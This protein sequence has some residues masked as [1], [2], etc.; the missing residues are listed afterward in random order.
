M[1]TTI[2]LAPTVVP[3][4]APPI[5]DGGV[6]S[7]QGRIIDVGERDRLTA[8]YP[9]AEKCEWQGVMVPGL[10]NAH[11]HL[12]YT[13]FS[14]VGSVR[15]PDY[16]TWSARFVEEYEERR[17][18]DWAQ[19]ARDG[20]HASLRNGTT[21]FADIVTDVA[22]L[23]ILDEMG[24]AGVAYLEV[25]GVDEEAWKSHVEE[26]LAST[27]AEAPISGDSTVGISPHAPYSLDEP[28]LK[29]LAR[30]ANDM[31]RRLHIHLAESDTEDDYYRNGRGALA[32]R[33]AMRV[34]RPWGVLGRGG[35]GMGAAEFA[36]SCGLLGPTTHVAHGVYLG[37]DGRRIL[38]ERNTT[39]ALCPRS[40][41]GVGIDPPPIRAFL[42][43]GNPIA[44]GTDSLGSSPSLDLMADVALLYD[45][46]RDQG[47][48][49][50]DLAPRLL[51]AATIGG[52]EAM[53]TRGAVGELVAGARADLA[54][55]DVDPVPDQVLESLVTQGASRCSATVVAGETRYRRT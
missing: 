15:H 22:A 48:Q 6:V 11:T 7:R 42:E 16:V 26:T 30:L 13:S 27:V 9:D 51:R 35:T 4:S 37:K 34:G 49:G 43:E 5:R 28:V 44:V 2:H 36:E 20:V 23:G 25:I 41:L 46:A 19:S 33:V 14:S 17:N 1:T 32:E 39:T 53:G 24:V 47:Y 21:C 55:F 18:D 31:G 40:N 54:V 45:L 12:Q 10:V 50:E 3:V 52:A 38:R 8:S 29:H